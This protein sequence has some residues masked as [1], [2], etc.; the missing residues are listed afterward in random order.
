MF[1][2]RDIKKYAKNL[3]YFISDWVY[4]QIF[5]LKI[6]DILFEFFPFFFADSFYIKAKS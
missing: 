5:T 3:N 2:G 1:E 4:L 6:R